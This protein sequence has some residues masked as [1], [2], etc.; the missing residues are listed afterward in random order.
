MDE[1]SLTDIIL[2][3]RKHFYNFFKMFLPLSIIFICLIY[4]QHQ[5]K[6]SSSYYTFS[7]SL[8]DENEL[9]LNDQILH[10]LPDSFWFDKNFMDEALRESNIEIYEKNIDEKFLSKFTIVSGLTTIDDMITSVTDEKK[11][12]QFYKNVAI[13]SDKLNEI[14]SN[15]SSV[16]QTYKTV[17]IDANNLPLTQD[18]V[19][20]LVQSWV[21]VVNKRLARNMNYSN[22]I[23]LIQLPDISLEM[24]M[25]ELIMI[26]QLFEI[27]SDNLINLKS[28]YSQFTT[29]NIDLI[30]IRFSALKQTVHALIS[31][32]SEAKQYFSEE[33]E[34]KIQ[35]INKKMDQLNGFI[36]GREQ[37]I[38]KESNAENIEQL[39]L[40]GSAIE[41][42]IDLGNL[43]A[44]SSNNS[45][46]QRMLINLDDKKFYYQ[47]EL[48]KL[49]HASLFL[50]DYNI[51]QVLD[52]LHLVIDDTNDIISSLKPLVMKQKPLM[53][54]SSPKLSDLNTKNQIAKNI[55]ISILIAFLISLSLL[56]LLNIR[57]NNN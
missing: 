11:Y 8:S 19:S 36:D 35:H 52:E 54:L 20:I 21:K 51:A 28:K 41:S 34:L 29:E 45:E 4:F 17:Y 5:T 26:N 6:S 7:V 16:N 18:E 10:L 42:L 15:L 49:T 53:L 55:L 37:N 47:N 3:I 1:I 56:V 9:F 38:K 25:R 24:N 40:S 57:R 39:N 23:N 27:V 2:L 44:S 48:R 32:N 33:L 46:Y 30:S 43:I 31:E 22:D 13:N 12:D 14:L 50:S